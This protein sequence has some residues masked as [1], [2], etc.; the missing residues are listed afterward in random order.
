MKK[1]IF[2]VGAN[3]GASC[4]NR[5][6]QNC[7]VY[8]FEPTPHLLN[9]YLLPRQSDNYIV[10]PKAISDYNGKAT[11]NIAAERGGGC[12]SLNTFSDGLDKTWPNRTDFK[13]TDTVEVDVMRMDTFIEENNIEYINWLHCDTQGND[14][15]V[16]KSFGEKIH[17]LESG[18]VEAFAKNP[19]YKESDNSKEAIVEFLE[20]NNFKIQSITSNDPYNNEL[21]VSFSK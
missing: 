14:L 13:V 4:F 1:I 10:V 9:K 8:A 20:K 11:F 17:I 21:N 6:G 19:L 7:K 15:K 18:V 3:N 2:D 16:L 5:S 12:S